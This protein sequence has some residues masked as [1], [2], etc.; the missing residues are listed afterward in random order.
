[1]TP[2]KEEETLFQQW[3]SAQKAGA[4]EKCNPVDLYLGFQHGV[5]AERS[6]I[7]EKLIRLV[8]D[9]KDGALHTKEQSECFEGEEKAAAAARAAVALSCANRLHSI[10]EVEDGIHKGQ[11]MTRADFLD[12]LASLIERYESEH[13]SNNDCGVLVQFFDNTVYSWNGQNLMKID[14][15]ASTVLKPHINT[16]KSWRDL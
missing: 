10:I 5:A 7:Q 6:R 8:G 15:P 2:K 16:G 12:S 1:M 11:K 4:F 3:L 13:P 14:I 9:W